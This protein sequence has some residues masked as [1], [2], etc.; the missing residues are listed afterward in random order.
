MKEETSLQLSLKDF[1]AWLLRHPNCILRAGTPEVMVHDHEDFHW[2][3]WKDESDTRNVQIFR[4]KR[5]VAE[6]FVIEETVDFVR[7]FAGEVEGEFIFELI[8]MKGAESFVSY[9]FV[10]SHGLDEMEADDRVH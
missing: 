1:W 8:V 6:F 2:I 5:P 3:L 10:M 7:G 4:G 9:F